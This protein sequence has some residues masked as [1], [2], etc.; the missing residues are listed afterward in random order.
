[1]T[2]YI[3]GVIE[4]LLALSSNGMATAVGVGWTVPSASAS[5][6]GA[7]VCQ[8]A[9]FDTQLWSDDF[10]D[11]D[12]ITIHY[13]PDYQQDVETNAS[14][15]RDGGWGVQ[16]TGTASQQYYGYFGFCPY[17]W[18][19]GAKIE[20]NHFRVSFDRDGSHWIAGQPGNASLLVYDGDMLGMLFE[21]DEGANADKTKLF[22][23]LYNYGTS[24]DS[25]TGAVLLDGTWETISV[26]VWFS[27][28]TESPP[29][30]FTPNEDGHIQVKVD[31]SIQDNIK[32]AGPAGAVA[33]INQVAQFYFG[34]MG[35]ADNVRICVDDT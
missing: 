16:T 27:T 31:G 4:P 33:G 25:E 7:G 26:E 20:T 28:W 12:A 17:N 30:T 2:V 13:H 14:A 10:A 22:L 11:G 3:Q 1:M 21:L 15:G 35:H 32:M 18:E 8:T 9:G 5:V 6:A 23:W 29:G 19:G 24:F 34:P